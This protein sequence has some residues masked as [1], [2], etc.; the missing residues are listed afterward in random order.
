MP[1]SFVLNL[2]ET[3]ID[4]LQVYFER[5]AQE[6]PPPP[7]LELIF[8]ELV[9]RSQ[10][11]LVRYIARRVKN[12]Y[13]IED[14]LQITLGKAFHGRSGYDSRRG[15]FQQWL[16][17]IASHNLANHFQ[18]SNRE[19]ENLNAWAAE[20]RQAEGPA[21]PERAFLAKDE[22]QFLEQSC[23]EEQD[24]KL[25]EALKRRRVEKQSWDEI[26]R[27][28]GWEITPQSLRVECYRLEKRL[29]RVRQQSNPRRIVT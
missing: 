21:N 16:F 24:K 20:A 26:H 6:Q 4:I 19:Q 17:G 25:L 11:N 13:D 3:P 15:T 27:D 2:S 1:S 23:E 12:P 28:M 29:R 22:Y 5:G 14:L 7:Y 9:A 10:K 18:A 8:M